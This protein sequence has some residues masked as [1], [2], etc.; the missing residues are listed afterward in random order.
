MRGYGQIPLDG[1]VVSN[2][3]YTDPTGPDQTCLRLRPGLRQSLV[4]VKFHY[5]VQ[6]PTNF[7]NLYFTRT[8]ISGSKT[9]GK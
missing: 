3:H 8:N 6:G 9:S 1:R 4:R 5:S 7:E 2:F